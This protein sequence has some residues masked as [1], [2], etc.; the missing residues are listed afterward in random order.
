MSSHFKKLLC[1][2]TAVVLLTVQTA[3]VN[4]NDIR[5]IR[6]LPV[7]TASEK[8]A[9]FEFDESINAYRFKLK[10][11]DQSFVARDASGRKIRTEAEMK[12]WVDASEAAHRDL[13]TPGMKA[14]GFALGVIYVPIGIVVGVAENVVGIPIGLY[15]LAVKHR[16][17][18]GAEA[19]YRNGREEF[20]QGKYTDAVAAWDRAMA[21]MPSLKGSSDIDYWR[22]RAFEAL[23]EG[24]SAL[25]AYRD[26]LDYSERSIP[27]YFKGPDFND[28]TWK[29]KAKDAESRATALF[30]TVAVR[31]Q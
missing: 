13:W 24:P 28:Q 16:I 26:F 29:E 5:N 19:M 15:A 22:G 18:R 12:Q 2:G 11:S 23:G 3:C 6:E 7:L 10:H 4:L 31:S 25:T 8:N 17:E 1:L 14:T 27:D 30:R 9:Q 20:D 21:H